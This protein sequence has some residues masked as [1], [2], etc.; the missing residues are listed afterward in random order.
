MTSIIGKDRFPVVVQETYVLSV[1]AGGSLKLDFINL[2][3][4]AGLYTLPLGN[5]G[6]WLRFMVHSSVDLVNQSVKLKSKNGAKVYYKGVAYDE[7]GLLP[8]VSR[9]EILAF[10]NKDGNWEVL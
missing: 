6:G 5:P 3:E 4:A 7:L 10:I 1:P 8:G 2:I 9:D